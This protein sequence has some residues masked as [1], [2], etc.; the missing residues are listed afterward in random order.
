M[1]ILKVNNK[2][3]SI[4]IYFEELNYWEEYDLILSLLEKENQCKVIS[5]QGAIYAKYSVLKIGNIEFALKHDD[6]L[7]NYLYTTNPSDVPV[8]ER[9]AKNVINSIKAKLKKSNQ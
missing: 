9:L 1:N 3:G 6:M 5:N 8:L 2:D 7:G 4:A